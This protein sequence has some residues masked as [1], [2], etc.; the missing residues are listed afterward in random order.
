MNVQHLILTAALVLFACWSNETVS[1]I[2]FVGVFM[3]VLVN[4]EKTISI[5]GN[6]RAPHFSTPQI[7]AL[8]TLTPPAYGLLCK[9][10]HGKEHFQVSSRVYY[11][12]AQRENCCRENCRRAVKEH[13]MFVLSTWISLGQS[14]FLS[15]RVSELWCPWK[16]CIFGIYWCKES[17]VWLFTGD[18]ERKKNLTAKGWKSHWTCTL[19]AEQ[20]PSKLAP[21]WR[22]FDAA[23]VDS[24][25]GEAIRRDEKRDKGVRRRADRDRWREVKGGRE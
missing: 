20:I 24:Q 21:S 25:T 16:S 6:F 12:Q 17:S 22:E 11:L 15:S 18:G 14:L 3:F 10:K 4:T 13:W 9:N 8:I 23:L 5:C 7:V 2:L 1:I 19:M